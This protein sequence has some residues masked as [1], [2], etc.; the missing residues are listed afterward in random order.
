LKSVKLIE[1]G[2]LKYES[3]PAENPGAK[4]AGGE[5]Q[6]GR[7]REDASTSQADRPGMDYFSSPMGK[8][9][10]QEMLEDEKR[11]QKLRKQMIKDGRLII[12]P[13]SPE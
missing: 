13:P 6:K 12:S 9:D 8:R 2:A 3:K 11:R 4:G 10:L 1:R 5:G 7:G